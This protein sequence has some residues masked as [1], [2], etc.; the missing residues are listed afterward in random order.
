MYDSVSQVSIAGD[1]V[2]ASWGHPGTPG[3]APGFFSHPDDAML[4]PNG[5]LLLADIV[6]CRILVLSPGPFHVVRQFGT[7]SSCY[8]DPPVTFGSPNGVFPMT[9]G[10]FLVTEINGDW[11]DA[12]SLRGA[13]AWST[14][15]PGVNY[16]S[17]SNQIRPGRYL[18]VDYSDRGQVVIFDRHGHALWRYAG[19]GRG[20][21]NHPSLALPLPNGDIAV[22]DDYDHRVVIINP[23][24][25]TIVWQ[26][27]VDHRA[28][29]APGYLDNPDGIDLVP[30][31]S[32]LSR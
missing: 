11:V 9:D 24:T 7:T 13:V 4:L 32:L 6:N 30:P 5:D 29:S 21:L 27:G 19:T 26:Y 20:T 31:D 23:R 28:G 17:D 16:P 18:T 22:N 3:S 15:P 10:N 8:H 25:K 2:V 1:R 12:I 14:H